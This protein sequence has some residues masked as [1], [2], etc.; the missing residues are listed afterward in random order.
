MHK[1]VINVLARL[2][3]MLSRDAAMSSVV[4]FPCHDLLNLCCDHALNNTLSDGD[5]HN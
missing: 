2:F 5:V 4:P 3:L 1:D